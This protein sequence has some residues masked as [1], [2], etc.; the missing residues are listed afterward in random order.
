MG[1]EIGMRKT[2]SEHAPGAGRKRSSLQDSAGNRGPDGHAREGE[3]VVQVGPEKP[4]GSTR[5]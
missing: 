2:V 4:K 1:I 3:G 5:N